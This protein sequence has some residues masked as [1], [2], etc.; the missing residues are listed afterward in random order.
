M[1]DFYVSDYLARRSP[2]GTLVTSERTA[3]L[4]LENCI[5]QRQATFRFDLINGVTGENLGQ[6]YPIDDQPATISHDVSRTIKRDLRLLFDPSDAAEINVLT[7]RIL[8]SMI[9]AGRTWPLG[10]FMFTSRV[11]SINTGGDDASIGLMD[12]MWSVDQ[13]ITTGFSS[14]ASVDIAVLALINGILVVSSEIAASPFPATGSWRVGSRRG[15][16]IDA[17]AA[18]GDYE[19][20][21]L[22]NDGAFRMIRTVDPSATLP[23]ITW[24]D[25]YPV[26]ADTISRTDNLIE[27]PNRFVVIGNGTA[28]ATSESGVVGTYDVPPTAPHSIAN[29]GFVLQQTVDMGVSTMAQAMAAA[30]AIGISQ[31]VVEQIDATTPP[32]P[33]HDSYDVIRWNG[34]NWLETAWSME[35]IEGGDMSHTLRR[36]F[37]VV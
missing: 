36:G 23:A 5:G 20:P 7:D 30:R 18:L 19:T 24:D 34:S 21:W 13:E 1:S 37:A 29:R 8:P 9:L 10:R 17:L 32:D 15:Q 3:E 33:R 25:T 35:L 12:E 27:A 2:G 4:D 28:S 16:I 11:D 6:L 31:T 26:I 14:T 22:S